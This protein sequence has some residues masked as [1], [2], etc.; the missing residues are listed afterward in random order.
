LARVSE[1]YNLAAPLVSENKMA[2]LGLI[3]AAGFLTLLGW[4]LF[5]RREGLATGPA[6]QWGLGDGLSFLNIS[7]VLL[8]TIGGFG[9][10]IAWAGL[11]Q[12][13]GY[14]RIS[15]YI[16]F[17]AIMAMALLAEGL[18]RR[19]QSS[20]AGSVAAIVL[21]VVVC[22]VGIYDQVPSRPPRAGGQAVAAFRSDQEF[23][24][25]VEAVLPKGSMVYQLPFVPFP[26]YPP[27]NRMVDYDHLK[28][29][30]HSESLRWSYGAMRGRPMH[31]W[32][33]ALAAK[34]LDQL[35]R[36][37]SQAGFRGIYVDRWGYTDNGAGLEAGL[38]RLLN[39][40]PIVSGDK[41]LSFF[42]LRPY[43]AAQAA[44]SAGGGPAETGPK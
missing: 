2:S 40:E 5:R 10:V 18:R 16:G 42:D 12:I 15:I 11:P 39:V 7:S 26:E 33:E 32:H 22:I 41:R 3:G 24:A 29:P 23:F 19:W 30:L 17:F 34:P 4:L 9:A 28:G 8:G 20:R 21:P 36:G 37:V 1:S 25:R 35:V 6:L 31:A 44:P 13:R 38:R 14:N 27:V 43:S